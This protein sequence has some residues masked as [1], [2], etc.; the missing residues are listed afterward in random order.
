MECT[1]IQVNS[2]AWR[3]TPGECRPTRTALL[4]AIQT[5][6][7]AL[8]G[9][10]SR[11][12]GYEFSFKNQRKIA[13]LWTLAELEKGDIPGTIADMAEVT[14]TTESTAGGTLRDLYKMGMLDRVKTKH[15]KYIYSLND[16]FLRKIADLQKDTKLLH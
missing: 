5:R 1:G 9:F 11:S 7:Y 14:G 6:V 3:I 10:L 8:E 13:F 15:K 4:N 2:E 16:D 12:R